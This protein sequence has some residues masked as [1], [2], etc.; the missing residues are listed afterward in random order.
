MAFCWAGISLA[1]ST[2]RAD[3]L[4]DDLAANLVPAVNN[5]LADLQ[6]KVNAI[7]AALRAIGIVAS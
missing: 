1:S 5:N 7:L 2:W 3:A 4:R 6:A